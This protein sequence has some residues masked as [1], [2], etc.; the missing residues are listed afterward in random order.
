MTQKIEPKTLKGFYDYF[1]KDVKIRDFVKN[2]FKRIAISY[3]FEALET[4]TL[5]YSE[6][7]LGQSGEEAEKLYYRFKDNGGRDVMLKYELMIPMCRA[8]GQNINNIQMPYKRYQIQNVWRA[9]NIQKGRLRELTQMDVDILG[10]NSLIADAQCIQFGLE[11]LRELG[12]Q[13]YIVL[14]SNRK[15]VQGL[16]EVLGIDEKNFEDVYIAIDKIKKIGI[17]GIKEELVKKNI[18]KDKIDSLLKILETKEIEEVEKVLEKS[19][20]GTKGIKEVE[21][22]LQI[23]Q[24]A[25]IRKEYM[26]FDISLTRGLASYTGPVWEFEVTDGNVGSVSGGGRYDEAVGKY[27]NRDIPATGTSFGLERLSLIMAEKN[28]I[29]LEE[30][31]NDVLLI[32]MNR[33]YLDFASK[34]AEEMRK[35]SIPINIYPDIEKLKV[36]FKYADRKQIPWVIVIGEEEKKEE[37]VKLKNMKTQEQYDLFIQEAIEKIVKK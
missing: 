24:D 15:I 25:G 31:R 2:T 27:I 17:E 11:F 1:D 14:L 30:G 18:G 36:S 10:S 19:E 13:K 37:R 21:E 8:V 26:K 6:L 16:I 35:N 7:I 29:N 23:L 4:P 5:E 9:E 33:E 28:M 3:G 12:F 20:V 34:V 32:C 22:I